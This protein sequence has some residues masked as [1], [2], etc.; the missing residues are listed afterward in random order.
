MIRY[1]SAQYT[2]LQTDDGQFPRG[3]I[4]EVERRPGPEILDLSV[5]FKTVA[6]SPSPAH[7]SGTNIHSLFLTWPASSNPAS[8]TEKDKL[9]HC[10]YCSGG[11]GSGERR[12]TIS[13]LSTT[14]LQSRQLTEILKQHLVIKIRGLE[15]DHA[16]EHLLYLI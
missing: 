10:Y 8:T 11:E 3:A 1:R 5:P 9:S 2:V 7:I 14:W 15:T 6:V 13:I 12:V 4:L 16:T